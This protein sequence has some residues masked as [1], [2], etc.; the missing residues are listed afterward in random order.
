[1]EKDMTTYYTRSHIRFIWAAFAAMM[2]LI[3]L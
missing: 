3:A 1:M 2:I